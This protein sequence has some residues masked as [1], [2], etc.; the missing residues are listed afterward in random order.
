MAKATTKAAKKKPPVKADVAKRRRGA[1]PVRASAV[2]TALPAM[3]P[4]PC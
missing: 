4:M 2:K 3:P 1:R